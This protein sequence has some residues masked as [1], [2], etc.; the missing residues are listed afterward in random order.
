M[1]NLNAMTKNTLLNISIYICKFFRFI[2]L[3]FFI[4]FT[5]V[6]V[7]YQFSPN[8]YDS[9][10]FNQNSQNTFEFKI[11]Q[12]S[13][14]SKVNKEIEINKMIALTTIDSGSLFFLYFRLATVLILCYF[15]TKE[16]QNVITSV[17]KMETFKKNN[18]LA[19]KRIGI[20]L[21]IF[22]LITAFWSIEYSIS[23]THHEHRSTHLSFTPLLMML[24]T[25]I[26]A[27]IFK[28]GHKISEENELTV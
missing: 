27:E 10:Y 13:P 14:D 12:S 15:I 16:F 2:Y 17:K 22:F 26:M 7:H 1:S 9:V 19:F 3:L 28:E 18:A 21:L 8:S 20:Y 23:D 25:F 5:V 24:F 6:F 4:G 11:K